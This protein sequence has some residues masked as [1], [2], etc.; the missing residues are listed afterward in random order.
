MTFTFVTHDKAA[1]GI[2]AKN[3]IN[4]VVVGHQRFLK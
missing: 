1:A 4:V 3:K 2:A